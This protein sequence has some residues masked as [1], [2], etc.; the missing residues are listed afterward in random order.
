[1]HTCVSGARLFTTGRRRRQWRNKSPSCHTCGNS[2][3]QTCRETKEPRDNWVTLF[4]HVAS[5][6]FRAC[7]PLSSGPRPSLQRPAG[8]TALGKIYSFVTFDSHLACTRTVG[9]SSSR[10]R[11]GTGW[12]W[13]RASWARPRT[14]R[15]TAAPI[16]PRSES[17]TGSC[18]AG[19]GL[20][21]TGGWRHKWD[22]R[23]K[24]THAR[25]PVQE[26][27][28]VYELY[29]RAV[30]LGWIV[31]FNFELHPRLTPVHV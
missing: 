12:R 19:W 31:L 28:A 22:M 27:G 25:V 16:G 20:S 10:T 8:W 14:P 7:H 21:I 29:N 2:A 30:T 3:P 15:Q 5:A 4:I 9:G 26:A 13:W 24:Q 6:R 17:A 1:M 11:C 18:P 23:Y